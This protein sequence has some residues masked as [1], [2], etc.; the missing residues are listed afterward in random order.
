MVISPPSTSANPA[1]SL[2]RDS[3]SRNSDLRSRAMSR[4]SAET[5]PKMPHIVLAQTCPDITL[6]QTAE[7]G[8]FARQRGE[9]DHLTL[10]ESAPMAV[11]QGEVVALTALP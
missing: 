10:Q 5:I 6:A 11:G 7:F 2:P 8:V 3:D 1:A 9:C 4:P